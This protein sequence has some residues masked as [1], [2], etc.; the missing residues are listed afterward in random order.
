[1]LNRRHFVGVKIGKEKSLSLSL[2]AVSRLLT[3]RRPRRRP[4][5]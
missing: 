2:R 1:L 5:R 3:A 4:R